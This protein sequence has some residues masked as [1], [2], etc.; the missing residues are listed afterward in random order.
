MARRLL[1]LS[2]VLVLAAAA[3][4]RPV[5]VRG[6]A[7]NR[8]VWLWAWQSGSATF[9][10]SV[11]LAPVRIDFGLASGF[12][13]FSMTTDEKTE[14]YYTGGSYDIDARLA[15]QRTNALRYCSMVGITVRLGTQ[16]F[17]IVNGCLELKALWPPRFT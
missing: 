5:A 10:N 3:L 17:Q 9:T 6:D 7:L 13:H 12:D 15:G 1:W 2:A 8:T 4:L 11:T 14:Q 16:R